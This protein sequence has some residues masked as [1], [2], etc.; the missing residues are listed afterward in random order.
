MTH[1][2][3]RDLINYARDE[4]GRYK[5]FRIIEHCKECPECADK[6]IAAA[7][8]HAPDPEPFRLSKWNKIS[9][10]VMVVALVAVAFGMWWLLRS[11]GQAAPGLSDPPAGDS[12]PEV[13]QEGGPP[14]DADEQRL[15]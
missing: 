5:K 7:R 9:I 2:D 6:L 11:V 4:L 8:D 13:P 1:P 10:V 3:E 15:G 12:V 14:I